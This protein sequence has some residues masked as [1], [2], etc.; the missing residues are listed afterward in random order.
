L[1]INADTGGKRLAATSSSNNPQK[2]A[3]DAKPGMYK[4]SG[5]HAK[6][7]FIVDTTQ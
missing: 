3:T 4:G 5:A 6:S 2:R 7:Q 1:Q